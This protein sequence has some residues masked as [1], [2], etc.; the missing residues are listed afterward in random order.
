MTDEPTVSTVD[1]STRLQCR[2]GPVGGARAPRGGG[3]HWTQEDLEE[4]ARG[5]PSAKLF[6]ELV[7]E[8]LQVLPRWAERFTPVVWARM[9]KVGDGAAFRAPR[10]VK[11]LNEVV[12]VVAALRTWIAQESEQFEAP[13]TVVDLCSGFGFLAMFLSELLAPR[14]VERI[15]LVDRDFANAGAANSEGRITNDHVYASGDWRIPLLT[16][17]TNLKRGTQLRSLH[18]RLIESST[19][20]VALLGVHLCN[21][22]SLRA[23]QLFNASPRIQ[24]FALAPCCLPSKKHVEKKVTYAS[25]DVRFSAKEVHSGSPSSNFTAWVQHV[26]DGVHSLPEAKSVE[27]HDV[28]DAGRKYARHKGADDTYAQNA[29]IFVRRSRS[30]CE[31]LKTQVLDASF[32]PVVVEASYLNG[33]PQS[34]VGCHNHSSEE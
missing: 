20:P 2:S 33:P 3:W 29:F 34:G 7:E 15:V 10:L 17:K 13:C 28:H 25:G 12:P 9:L 21:T 18:Q 22:L 32:G 31:A 16:I 26:A 14:L 24:F 4:M 23:V 5:L 19:G 11:E 6:P 27:R 1:P 30:E 8:M